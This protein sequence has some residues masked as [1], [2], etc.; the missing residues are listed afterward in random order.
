MPDTPFPKALAKY[1]RL[2]QSLLSSYD[3][4]ALAAQFDLLYRKGYSYHPQGRGQLAH[5]VFA[6]CFQEMAMH[7]QSRIEPDVATAILHEVLRQHDVDDVCHEPGCDKAAFVIP[8]DERH[9]D[10]REI[11]CPAGHRHYSA[12]VNVPAR[13][14][15]D[16]RWIVRKWANDNE[17][18]IR[19]LVDVER[20][21]EAIVHYPN[22]LGGSVE[23][24]L[25]GQLDALFVDPEDSTHA[26]VID[27]KD[28]WKLPAP[29]EVSFEG[30]FQQRFYAMLVLKN[31][32]SIQKVT[33]RE[34]YVR[35]SEVREATLTRENLPDV[36][37]DIS[38]IMERFDRSVETD[39]WRPTAGRHC[40]F[41]ARPQACPIPVHVRQEGRI[42]DPAQAER[43]GRQILV[44]E[45]V[46]EQT[47]KA[48][49]SYVDVHGPVP[50][51]DSKGS[52]VWAFEEVV[53]VT[54]P[55]AEEVAEAVR[56]GVD[57][58][59]LF[60]SRK[61]TRFGKVTIKPGQ[62]EADDDA[63]HAALKASLL[64]E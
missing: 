43:L 36:E 13:E 37:A 34:C 18:D 38:A 50:I 21:L 27:H 19:H 20:R 45:V 48:L 41:C 4:C 46:I 31:Y 28:T 11:G 56:S 60:K 1:P 10:G 7:D 2:R 6:K 42:T 12:V 35:R 62:E 22:P 23:R 57:P 61:G 30:Y 64:G 47:R 51:K 15:D 25:T 63:L 54:K 59:T 5:R 3:D 29:T 49:S 33:L 9:E 14:R 55:T 17:F 32:R 16:L 8:A 52:T 39:V 53:R 40:T 24:T 58:T 44:A 26:I